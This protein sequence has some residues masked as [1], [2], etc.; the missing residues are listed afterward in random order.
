[1]DKIKEITRYI[2]NHST[3]E[4][5]VLK[6]LVRETHVK[7]LY[8]QMLSGHLQGKFLEFISH[9][10]QPEYILEIGTFTGYS[11]ICLAKGLKCSG[12]LITIEKNDELTGFPLKYFK[13]AGIL[14]KIELIIGDALDIIP[15]L[16]HE[17]DL[18]FID[19][20]KKDYVSY[21][22]LLIEKVKPG[23]YILADN[24]LW[25]GRV[26]NKPDTF[27]KE[28]QGIVSFNKFINEDP[29]VENMILPI[30]DGIM[31]IRK[32]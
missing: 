22:Q 28:T 18:V 31:L 26:I 27:D 5:P 4:D 14:E 20:E 12:K 19:A 13:K 3:P 6:E 15:T 25:Y 24:A 21:Y 1:M 9:M 23:G 7:V 10:L 2:E 16:K 32:I 8:P 11:A 30:R 29:R 17:F